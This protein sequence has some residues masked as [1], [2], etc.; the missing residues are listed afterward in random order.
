MTPDEVIAE[1]LLREKPVLD[2]VG[3]VPG[4]LFATNGYRQLVQSAGAGDDWHAPVA[5]VGLHQLG[6]RWVG[7][8]DRAQVEGPAWRG[9]GAD[10][11]DKAIITEA[12]PSQGLALQASI[13]WLISTAS[14]QAEAE[15]TTHTEH[16]TFAVVTLDGAPHLATPPPPPG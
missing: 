5:G 12:L 1:L 16:G 14:T 6:D 3:H 7:T 15:W 8:F 4:L 9:R 10:A 2:D 11:P 13:A